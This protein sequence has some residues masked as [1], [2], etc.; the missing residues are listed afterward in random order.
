MGLTTEILIT[1][2][3]IKNVPLLINALDCQSVRVWLIKQKWY[4]D[5]PKLSLGCKGAHE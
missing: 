1:I 4:P 5:S 2:T 3:E